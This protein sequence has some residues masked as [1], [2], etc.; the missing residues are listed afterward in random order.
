[1]D[2]NDFQIEIMQ[3]IADES[4]LAFVVEKGAS[5]GAEYV[6]TSDNYLVVARK[7]CE[8][9]AFAAWQE[10]KGD[11]FVGLAWTQ[12][13]FRRRGLYM[14]LFSAI[15]AEAKKQGLASIVAGVDGA[16]TVSL[17]AHQRI[18]GVPESVFFKRP[19]GEK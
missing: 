14:A 11:A 4:L 18:F 19:C 5:F 16:N 13:E 9:V 3:S 2:K 10:W 7:A 17:I 15:K 6:P 1:M 8:V 12:P